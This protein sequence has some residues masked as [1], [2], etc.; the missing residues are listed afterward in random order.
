MDKLLLEKIKLLIEYLYWHC[1]CDHD[2]RSA[3]VYNNLLSNLSGIKIVL[4]NSIQLLKKSE[5][6]SKE[7]VRKKLEE[8]VYGLK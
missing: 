7:L 8:V 1:G 4:I 5:I 2:E 6:N 3:D